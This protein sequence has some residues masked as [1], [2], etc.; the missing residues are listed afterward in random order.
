MPRGVRV[1]ALSAGSVNQHSRVGL[2][3]DNRIITRKRCFVAA[4]EQDNAMAKPFSSI[5][6][7]LNI[8]LGLPKLSRT[9]LTYS[10]VINH[11]HLYLIRLGATSCTHQLENS[12]F[13]VQ[14]TLQELKPP[15]GALRIILSESTPIGPRD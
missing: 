14:N 4:A 6:V 8:E 15:E 12:P 13:I 11:C 1:R 3:V 9:R 5:V 10:T 7:V 2:I